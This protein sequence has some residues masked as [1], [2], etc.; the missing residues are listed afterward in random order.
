VNAP[1]SSTDAA[2][3]HRYRPGYPDSIVGLVTSHADG[4]VSRALEVG[5]GTG[6]ATLVFAR[7]GIAVVAVE[8]DLRMSAELRAHAGEL[9]IQI[10]TS[11]FEQ[12]DP[13]DVGAFDLV[14]AAAAFHWTDPASRWERTAALLR[15]GGVAAF[16]GAAFD[17]V[18]A[19]LSEQVDQISDDVLGT[20]SFQVGAIEDGDDAEG[21]PASDLRRRPEFVDVTE[22]VLEARASIPADHFVSHLATVS[23]YQVLADDVRSDVLSRIRSALPETVDISQDV[24]VHMTRRSTS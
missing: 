20:D 12:L 9:P 6:K 1:R 18:D 3:Y 10:V 24:T 23:R 2:A 21:W 13:N 22:V 16:F 5:A 4:P 15:P 7:Q 19:A 17:L 8:P 11:S 14:F